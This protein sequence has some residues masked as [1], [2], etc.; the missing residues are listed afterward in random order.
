MIDYL[1]DL[2][3]ELFEKILDDIPSFDILSSLCLVNKG[4]RSLSLNYSR[5][6]I[7][8]NCLK[9]KK[10]FNSFYVYLSP[11][12]SRIVAISLS[13]SNDDTLP[14]KI[15]YFFLQLNITHHT[16]TNLRSLTLSHVDHDMW[17]SIKTYVKSFVSLTVLSIDSTDVFQKRCEK[18][19]IG[20]V[21]RF[22]I[23]IV[24]TQVSFSTND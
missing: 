9:K 17:R 22:I 6:Q 13:D 7:N 2:P 4:L 5:F 18:I 1:S 12:S 8:F 16:F 14:N 24:I 10:K 11:L 23:S 19:Y 20:F 15:D 21:K 3:V